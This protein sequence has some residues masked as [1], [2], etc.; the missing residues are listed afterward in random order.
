MRGYRFL[1]PAEDEMIE[2]SRFYQREAAG[3]GFE[4]LDDVERVVDALREYPK[5]GRSIGRGLRRALLR[6]F[7]FSLIYADEPDEILIVA[8]AH[9]RRRPGYWRRRIARRR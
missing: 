4:F 8:V 5:F 9:Q 6:R 2:A 1:P 3:L 7:P